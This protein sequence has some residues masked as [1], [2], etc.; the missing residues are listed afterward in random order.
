MA[1][2][3]IPATTSAGTGVDGADP[4]PRRWKALA[5]L[6]TATFITILDG[7]IVYVAVPS[8]ATDLALTPASL[9]WVLN[10]YL[11]VFGGLLLLCGRA[12]DLLGRR[13]LFMVGGALL[14]VSSLL[15]GLAGSA[16]MLI[17][18][19]VLQGLAGAIMTPTALSLITT[20]FREG[21]ERNKALGF[22]SVAGGIGGTTGALLGGPITEGL[23][24][25]W[26]FFLNVPVATLMVLL[27]PLVLRE[28][29]DRRGP[30]TFDVAGAVVS[31]AAMVLMVYAVVNAPQNGWSSG[32]TIGILGAAALAFALFAVI[33]KVSSAPLAPLRLFR[34][35]YL[36]G[37]NLVL[38]IVGMAVNGGMGFTLT[39]YAQV[40]LGY[41]AVQ[42]GLMFAVMTVLTIVGSM[43]AGGRL[44]T[45]Y[46][47]R[48]VAV[49]SLLLLG[50]S[51]LTLTQL[52]VDGS[53][54]S[55]MLLGMV[56][57]GPG[58]GAGFVAG[59]IAS[60]TGITERD[61]GLASGLNTASFHV[62][63]ALGIAI[64]AAVAL[65]QG[66]GANPAAAA[67]DGFNKAF[68]ASAVFVA[69]GLVVAVTMLGRPRTLRLASA[70]A[71]AA[72]RSDRAA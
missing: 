62:G 5:L 6:C 12:A 33:E 54:A 2:G 32:R 31:T 40:V 22:W 10:S 63:G 30:R 68:I 29:Y 9:Q 21:G 4:D 26:V 67:V 17:A 61:A 57:F 59:S 72:E 13:R 47:P 70:G 35:K 14:A 20:T 38:L 44:G 51:S 39:Q 48:P 25:S 3:R 45:R 60:L 69:V 53:F 58:L 42:F 50:I 64:M 16:A 56:L 28:S 15:C 52:S 65:T 11:L 1:S 7:T 23:G 18:A 55:D 34:S 66:V 71:P 8:L 43:L 27:S 41:S 49:I 24:W 36:V 19:R 46:G 37:G